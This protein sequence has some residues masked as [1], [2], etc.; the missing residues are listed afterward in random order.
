[1]GRNEVWCEESRQGSERRSRLSLLLM[2]DESPAPAGLSFL[3]ATNRLSD[4]AVSKRRT[5]EKKGTGPFFC[6]VYR[7]RLSGFLHKELLY[8]TGHR[9]L[10]RLLFAVAH[11]ISRSKTVQHSRRKHFKEGGMIR[12]EGPDIIVQQSIATDGV[13]V[14]AYGEGLCF[15]FVDGCR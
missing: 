13:L 7:G 12:G 8:F 6:G 15:H 3:M 10:I 14:D 9:L 1:M 4:G 5:K 11:I 2:S